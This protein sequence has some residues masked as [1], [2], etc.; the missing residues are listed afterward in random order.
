MVVLRLAAFAIVLFKI[1]LATRVSGYF[2]ASIPEIDGHAVV[3]RVT[4]A[5]HA[6]VCS[7]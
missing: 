2:W 6:L 5:C 1:V 4:I 7:P 3:Q